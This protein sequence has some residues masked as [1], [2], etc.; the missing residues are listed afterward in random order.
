[1]NKTEED[2]AA[3]DS[4]WRNLALNVI[5]TA[6][7]DLHGEDGPQSVVGVS[8]SK[9]RWSA[10]EFFYGENS[11]LPIY[12]DILGIPQEMGIPEPSEIAQAL[13]DEGFADVKFARI[14]I[15]H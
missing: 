13:L 10:H 8:K 11:N 2:K 4:A 5:I 9:S 12:L 1:M 7:A 15:G 6:I 3:I 14:A